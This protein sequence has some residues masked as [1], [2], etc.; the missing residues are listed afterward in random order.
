MVPWKKGQSGNPAGRPKGVRHKLAND[1]L[2]GLQAELKRRGTVV[3]TE[4]EAKDFV[5]VLAKVMPQ[6]FEIST[7]PENPPRIV[8]SWETSSES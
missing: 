2:E 8:I 7:D 3:F 5:N 4:L 6:N 1:F